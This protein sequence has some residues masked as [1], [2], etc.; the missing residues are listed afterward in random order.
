MKILRKTKENF[1]GNVKLLKEAYAG[2]AVDPTKCY[3]WMT[4]GEGLSL[5]SWRQIWTKPR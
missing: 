1:H 3:E 4:S 2:N 5:L